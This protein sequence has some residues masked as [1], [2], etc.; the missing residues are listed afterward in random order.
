M[1]VVAPSDGR[2]IDA[3][4]DVQSKAEKD[5][6][7]ELFLA[8]YEL[9]QRTFREVRDEQ[10]RGYNATRSYQSMYRNGARE[11]VRR[12][13]MNPRA[14]GFGRLG[15]ARRYDL[16]YEWFV[17]NPCWQFEQSVRQRAWDKLSAAR[18]GP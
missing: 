13:V 2:S 11:S 4:P 3:P 5:P 16:S 10:G 9:L 8:V 15:E 6:E 1:E 17:L 12:A 18:F 14:E 7:P